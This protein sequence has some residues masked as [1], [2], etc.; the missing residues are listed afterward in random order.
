MIL[1]SAV[2]KEVGAIWRLAW[3]VI[4][5]NVG[6]LLMGLVD[7]VMLGR[8]GEQA[9]GAAAIG[10]ILIFGLFV[11]PMGILAGLDPMVSQAYGAGNDA[12]IG[13]AVRRGVILALALSLPL[14][15][16]YADARWVLRLLGQPPELVPLAS[17]YIHAFA[18]SV[19]ISLVYQAYRHV[20]QS[21]GIVKPLMWI[22]L[23]ANLVNFGANWVLI[24]GV[25]EWGIPAYGVTGA[26]WAT[27]IA[28]GFMFAALLVVMARGAYLLGPRL[29]AALEGRVRVRREMAGVAQLFRVGFPVGMQ[30]SLEVWA[31]SLAGIMM[32]W[33]GT[34]PLAGHAV[35]I[36]LVSLVFM[37]PMGVSVAAAT[38]V[39]QSVGRGDA[40]GARR[41]AWTSL[42]LTA[43]IMTG[44]T[45]LFALFPDALAGLYTTDAEVVAMVAILLPIA[46]LFQLF[47]GSQVV[48]FGILRGA[49]DVRV[50][51]WFNLV[52]YYALG[53]P[54]GYVLAFK[55]GFGAQGVWAALAIGLFAVTLMILWRLRTRLRGELRP[56]MPLR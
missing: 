27:T 40:V 21:M 20:F 9:L 24:Y 55:L 13:R 3:P 29:A 48:G 26:G 31:F 35:A 56:L 7:T 49:G 53:L 51:M 44:A 54:I 12:A 34:L 14:V 28:R 23:S 4:L 5:G 41:V 10:N 30:V 22:V 16:I 36:N 43:A 6:F 37:V 15:V 17:E 38:R 39:G 50:A 33:L 11:L 8:L 46:A 42:G 25:P 19:T 47:D 2:R 52:G 18:F 45:L 32:G 1:E